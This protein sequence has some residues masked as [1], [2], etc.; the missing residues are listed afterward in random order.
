MCISI[1]YAC[2]CVCTAQYAHTAAFH[3]STS[4]AHMINVK[5]HKIDMPYALWC[6]YVVC[7]GLRAYKEFP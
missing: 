3:L 5:A 7:Y 4:E 1:H 2:M 6:V